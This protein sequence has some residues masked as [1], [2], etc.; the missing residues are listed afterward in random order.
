MKLTAIAARLRMASAELD[1][2]A[3]LGQ[4]LDL[5]DYVVPAF[6]INFV[7]DERMFGDWLRAL[8][9]SNENAALRSK[10]L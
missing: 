1:A 6:I 2:L 10:E 5:P 9:P 7:T 8:A 3:T 4:N